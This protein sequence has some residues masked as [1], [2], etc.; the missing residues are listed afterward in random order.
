MEC[1]LYSQAVEV[2]PASRSL[3]VAEYVTNFELLVSFFLCVY[4]Y[5]YICV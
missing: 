4:I 5:I 2:Y 1:S 3:L